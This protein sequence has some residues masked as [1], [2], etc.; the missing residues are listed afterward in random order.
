MWVS[1]VL[2]NIV[3]GGLMCEHQ[4]LDSHGSSSS[5]SF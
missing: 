4:F 2:M 5:S 1:M 3:G